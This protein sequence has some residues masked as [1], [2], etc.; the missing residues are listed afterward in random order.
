MH[1]ALSYTIQGGL[2]W[3]EVGL[4]PSVSAWSGVCHQ[5]SVP[6]GQNCQHFNDNDH[7]GPVTSQM[8]TILFSHEGGAAICIFEY[9]D[10]F[11]YLQ[12]YG[13]F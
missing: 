1:A 2:G 12:K 8:V 7:D 4:P 6:A 10:K 13:N 11:K 3:L 9:L 5:C